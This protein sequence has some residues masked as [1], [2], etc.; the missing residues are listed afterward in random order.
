VSLTTKEH[1]VI[2][3]YFVRRWAELT[4]EEIERD[5]EAHDKAD[6]FNKVFLAA[7]WTETI[8]LLMKASVPRTPAVSMDEIHSSDELDKRWSLMCKHYGREIRAPSSELP[9]NVSKTLESMKQR[10][11]R[12]YEQNVRKSIDHHL[13]T[14]PIEQLF[15]LEWHY[16]RADEMCGV[17]LHPQENVTTD[18][19]EYTI[20]FVVRSKTT[21]QPRG[22]VAIELDGHEFHEK[23]KQQVARDKKR[24]RAIV[25]A[26]LPVLRFSGHEI[27]K[28]TRACVQEV[29]DYFRT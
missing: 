21:N 26:G 27:W 19:G 8:E 16:R 2:W 7:R 9:A 18:G 4:I 5:I 11:A 28:S 25:R 20:D 29:I 10:V 1:L 24:E 22:A 17:T 12:D 14:S 3:T 15:L 23:T 13:V 6:P